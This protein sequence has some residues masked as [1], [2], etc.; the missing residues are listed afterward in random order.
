[1]NKARE[2]KIFK[3]ESCGSTKVIQKNSSYYCKYCNSDYVYTKPKGMISLLRISVGLLLLFTLYLGYKSMDISENLD[4]PKQ[5][6]KFS[7]SGHIDINKNKIVAIKDLMTSQL[8]P[9]LKMKREKAFSKWMSQS[10]YQSR[11]SNG[12][13]TRKQTYAAYLELDKYGNRRVLELPLELK[14]RKQPFY[15]TVKSGRELKN[16]QKTHL[17]RSMNGKRLLSMSTY[18][19][20]GTT[21]YSGTWVSSWA[22]EDEA[23]KLLEYGISLPKSKY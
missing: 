17:H 1:M 11:F 19:I 5:V 22:L 13:Y 18:K 23:S 14:T 2:I 4:K 21:F 16:F 7:A 9:H 3:C 12:Y 10:E 15:Y 8:A 6:K 20:H